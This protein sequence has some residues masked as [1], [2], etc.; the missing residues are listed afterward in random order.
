MKSK[1]SKF[2]GG[3]FTVVMALLGLAG[4]AFIALIVMLIPVNALAD[5]IAP[6]S[7][8]T[9]LKPGASVTITK[10]VTISAGTPGTALLDVFFLAD[11]TG[12]MGTAI[13]NVKVGAAAIMANI[14]GLGD[15]A[16]GVGE[17]K[18]YNA[19]DPFV[20]R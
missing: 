12:S 20:Y 6:S 13:N 10:T 17:Y 14:S 4:S 16:Y 1:A 19:Y 8:S 2:C 11:T 9:S 15:V 3:A 18:D 7:Y 5:S